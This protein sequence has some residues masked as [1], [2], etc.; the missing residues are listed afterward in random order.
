MKVN[1]YKL[2]LKCF[3]YLH[4]TIFSLD[5]EIFRGI[6]VDWEVRGKIYKGINNCGGNLWK[7]EYCMGKQFFI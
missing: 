3:V 5:F 2:N 6:G 4:S 7:W 1:K